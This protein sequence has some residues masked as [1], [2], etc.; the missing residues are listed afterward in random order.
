[1][2]TAACL[3]LGP[4]SIGI[5]PAAVEL[6]PTSAHAAALPFSAPTLVDDEKPYV[7]GGS[8]PSSISC[9]TSSLCFG[10]DQEEDVLSSSAPTAAEPSWT[11][12]TLSP[13]LSKNEELDKLETISCPTTK[14]C[15]ATDSRGDV[16]TSTDPTA[17]A[18]TSWTVKNLGLDSISYLACVSETLCI[19]INGAG[20]VVSST[21]PGAPTPTWNVTQMVIAHAISAFSCTA[22]PLCVVSDDD[23]DVF[24]STDPAGG[25]SKWIEVPEVDPSSSK[26]LIGLPTGLVD[27]SCVSTPATLCVGTDGEGNLVTSTEPAVAK[28]SSWK[29]AKFPE[30]ELT[31]VS[32]VASNQCFGRVTPPGDDEN[33]AD[34]SSSTTPTAAAS[35]SVHQ[36]SAT[37]RFGELTCRSGSGS[38]F[39]CFATAEDDDSTGWV[40]SSTSP[41]S[42]AA[43]TVA[44]VYGHN[45]LAAV[46]CPT[47]A[48]CVLG[49]E[50]GRVLASTDPTSASPSWSARKDVDGG[51]ELDGLSCVTTPSALCAAT[52]DEGEII[53]STDPASGASATWTATSI[54]GLAVLGQVSCTSASLCV[55]LADDGAAL[56]S[57][58]PTGGASKWTVTEG[59]DPAADWSTLSCTAAPSLLCVAVD[60]SGDVLTSTDPTAAHPT[61]TVK[62][63]VDAVEEITGY[64]FTGVS[65]ASSSLCVAVDGD[66]NVF[67]S[68]DPG[69]GA[70]ATW[71]SQ[72]VLAEGDLIE[73]VS[74]PSSSL[75]VATDEDGHAIVSVDPAEGA[76][77]TWT[78]QTIDAQ[79]PVQAVSCASA[80]LCVA[81]DTNGDVVIAAGGT[82][83]PTLTVQLPGTGTG[84]VSGS[85]IAC[86]S[87]C[88]HAYT[89]GTRVTLSAEA[90][91]GSTFTGW[92]GACSG[93]G[94]CEV[95]LTAG[96]TVSA[97]FTAATSHELSVALVG[98]GSGSV[99]GSEGLQCTSSCTREYPAGAHVTLA[100][101]PAA[102]ST[103]AGW[104]GACSGTGSC[105]VTLSAAEQVTA[106]FLPSG[107]GEATLS[108]G[109][110]ALIAHQ[111]P[112]AGVG[113]KAISCPTSGFCAA[114][115]EAGDVVVSTDPSAGA[116]AS[117]QVTTLETSRANEP[118]G[119]S[120]PS[121]SLCA[122]VTPSGEVLSSTNPAAAKPAWSAQSV[123]PHGLSAVSCASASLCVA[124]DGEGRVF[125]STDGAAKTW[126]S[127][128]V[129]P[130]KDLTSISCVTTPLCVAVDD[131]GE[132]FSSTDPQDG[133]SATWSRQ[134]AIDGSTTDLSGVSCAS[135]ALCAI[136]D[137]DGRVLTSTDP[138]AGTATKWSAK[139]ILESGLGLND[140]TAVSCPSS[141]LC[142]VL[143]ETGEDIVSTD[144]GEG[145]SAKW[146]SD[147]VD[148]SI[149]TTGLACVSGGSLCVGIDNRGNFFTSLDVTAGAT[150]SW[151]TQ[152]PDGENDLSGISCPSGELCVAVDGEGNILTS[153][154]PTAPAPTW[155]IK[156]G[157][158]S[159]GLTELTAVACPTSS[160]CVAVGYNGEI[161][162]SKDPQDGASATWTGQFADT[163]DANG[164]FAAVSCP[165]SS[166]CVAVDASGNVVS[167]TDPGAASP[168]WA[169]LHITA[170][171]GGFPD[172]TAVSCPS[173]GLCVALNFGGTTFT[174]TDPSAGASAQWQ[175]DKTGTDGP[176]FGLTCPS[177]GLCVA[178][179]EDAVSITGDPAAGAGAS[180]SLKAGTGF[181]GDVFGGVDV[182]C[183]SASL[184][185]VVDSTGNAYVSANPAAG[186]GSQW[187][188]T[189]IDSSQ[190]GNQTAG[191]D[192][193]AC[194]TMKLCVAVDDLGYTT[195][196]TPAGAS[197]GSGP[198]GGSGPSGG[199]GPQTGSGSGTGSSGAETKGGGT[200]SGSHSPSGGAG[201]TTPRT[202]PSA[203]QLALSCTDSKLALTE[204]LVHGDRVL[205]EGVAASSLI[206]KH[207]EIVFGGR[208]RVASAT[209][210]ANGSFSTSA[211]LPP[212]GARNGNRAR[213]QARAGGIESLALKLT[214]RLVL[215]P[216][217]S[218]GGRVTLTG[219]VTLPL[220][221]PI[222]PI[223][224]EQQVSCAKT[225]TVA[226]VKPA[227]SGRFTISVPA[228]RGQRAAIYR[229][230][231]KVR[232]STHSRALF[233]TFSL[234]EPVALG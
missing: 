124:T 175:E 170:Y 41:A 90:A 138:T 40:G 185:A 200:G 232:G 199:S 193:L 23:G 225:T 152:R 70:E 96:A 92:G 137:G 53:T 207:V 76:K 109:T 73:S 224:V 217:R 88:S 141:G 38:S 116:S 2:L 150:A 233:G 129:A 24:V 103:F 161:F 22:A 37:A 78:E 172:L 75:C 16:I 147:D 51:H 208:E 35:W 139:K 142:V 15:V 99:S 197:G 180:W 216:P 60:I 154:D 29:I 42:G 32:C 72:H 178:V 231:T 112:W 182:A 33:P 36:V 196:G 130:G 58:D 145:A 26:T 134:S 104:G 113:A 97:T 195:V 83:P 4:V 107:G 65:C 219:Q 188:T 50:G 45:P 3:G 209:V 55:A 84:S 30:D 162:T 136:V 205:L 115:D 218:S 133:A 66:G 63:G 5:G 57:T 108:W 148:G 105:E 111:Q 81:G 222:A 166:L 93:T 52:D 79:L 121:S 95:T 169:E 201:S 135:G 227:P 62:S 20:D 49:D 212:A 210:G 186:S 85:G 160:L 86:P 59:A 119:I 21:N 118:T 101:T 12:D 127:K 143:G 14:L 223:L 13:L 122:V 171:A 106:T 117:W 131:D 167:S 230:Q 229:L 215:D 220:A 149:F 8:G 54:P 192:A 234:P 157:E 114:V 214:R 179:G 204:V 25:A 128:E 18:S 28:K 120:C 228:P 176:N 226:R 194:P 168:H 69:E 39:E 89:S 156:P 19:G 61:W 110:P 177:V 10:I 132:A 190:A 43:W 71:S 80:A 74:C 187:S 206:G 64:S 146:A 144:P 6:G 164:G 68:T 126:T 56:A 125:V 221:Q 1:V 82:P 153:T 27:L 47:S 163:G 173:T 151:A 165:S 11:L 191:L 140:L 102:G 87:E 203:T 183:P 174:S 67:V 181:I 211:P 198:G 189:H 158:A 123:D 98:S 7:L 17:G 100:A 159:A 44:D 91:P 48:L 202:G 184:C 31:S 9:P 155:Q 34:I 94:T 213:Y 46:S 77:A